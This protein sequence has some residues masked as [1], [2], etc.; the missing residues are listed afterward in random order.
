M[1]WTLRGDVSAREVETILVWDRIVAAQYGRVLTLMDV[2]ALGEV[3]SETRK[4]VRRA[5][6]LPMRGIGVFGASFQARIRA[7]MLLTAAELVAEEQENNPL[8]FF[9]CEREARSWLMARLALL[10]CAA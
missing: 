1:C 3:P 7:T 9:S 10:E 5:Q 8:V 2:S 6:E 4:T